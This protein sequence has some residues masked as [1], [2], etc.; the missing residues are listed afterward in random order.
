MI[1]T[2]PE[3]QPQRTVAGRRPVL[4]ALKTGQPVEKI[5]LLH[6]AKGDIIGQ[7]QRL[8]RQLGI[9]VVDASR[10]RIETM[11]LGEGVQGIVAF[12]LE[13]AFVDIDELLEKATSKGEQPF[14]LILD[15]IE[16]PHNLGALIR[17]A[18]CTGAHGVV[19]P[20][21]HSA[22]LGQAAVKASAGAVL[23][24]PVARVTN[25]VQTLED[26]KSRGVWILGTDRSGE[27]TFD[28]VDYQAPIAIVVGNEGRGIRRLV[29]EKCD[30]LVRI[31]LYGKIE[32]LNA[33]VAGAIVMYEVAR[34][35]HRHSST[36]KEN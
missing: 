5:F 9:P 10:Q 18:E 31:P 22:P 25:I 23:H 28:E 4:E 11:D 2:L 36:P 12:L 26:L 30:F 20:K 6:G 1:S 32:S 33:S 34:A 3:N 16:D 27:R 14:L 24:V 21:H 15:E 29:K 35:R 7:I 17:S 13:Q 19:V 8:A